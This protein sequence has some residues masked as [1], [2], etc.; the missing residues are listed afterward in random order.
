MQ[1]FHYVLMNGN[2]NTTYFGELSKAAAFDATPVFDV[3]DGEN[4]VDMRKYAPCIAPVHPHMWME[5]HNQTRLDPSEIM[6][7]TYLRGLLGHNDLSDDDLKNLREGLLQARKSQPEAIGMS[8]GAY[9]QTVLDA[10][11][12]SKKDMNRVLK[13]LDIEDQDT[14]W[15]VLVHGF[16]KGGNSTMDTLGGYYVLPIYEDGTLVSKDQSVM[17][18]RTQDGY[19][20][21]YAREAFGYYLK[22]FLHT[23]SLLHCKNVQVEDITVSRQQRRQYQ[24]K[25]GEPLNVVKTLVLKP[26]GSHGSHETGVVRSPG[27]V[28]YHLMRG[29][30]KEFGDDAPLFGK[31]TGRYWWGSA[32]RGNPNRGRVEKEYQVKPPQESE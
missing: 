13:R 32:M 30:F 12:D 31:Y 18:L 24:H 27:M 7:D 26:M 5:V 1:F 14:R 19:I 29:H 8:A 4:S 28:R 3:F 11:Q 23:I 22:I 15:I 16:I 20:Y 21:E 6:S 9:F 2:L 17:F 25:T 10:S